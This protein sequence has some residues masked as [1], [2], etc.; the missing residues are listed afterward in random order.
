MRSP[1]R[2]SQRHTE[3]GRGSVAGVPLSHCQRWRKGKE[4][5]GPITMGA[6]MLMARTGPDD[7]ASGGSDL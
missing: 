3:A 2:Q 4:G 1:R 5:A 7:T 6:G